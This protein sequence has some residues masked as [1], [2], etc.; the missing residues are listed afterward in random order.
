[1]NAKEERLPLVL[2]VEDVRSYRLVL[3]RILTDKDDSSRL[4]VRLIE[5][6]NSLDALQ[7]LVH[8]DPS[9]PI[10]LVVS[11]DRMPGL[12][13]L[14]LLEIVG[15]RWPGTARM[16]LSGYTTGDLVMSTE[17]AVLDKGIQDWV[18]RDFIL[19]LAHGK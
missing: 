10:R 4:L 16:L 18:I 3:R 17:Y 19:K 12:S 5:A 14:E 7:V 8:Q 6:D 13:G 2:L 9:D 1:M 15:R 11:D